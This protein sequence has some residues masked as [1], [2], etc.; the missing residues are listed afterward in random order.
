M[1]RKRTVAQTFRGLAR[2]LSR[3]TA[4]RAGN[5]IHSL[6]ALQQ[7]GSARRAT[8][9][10]IVALMAAASVWLAVRSPQGEIA[11]ALETFFLSMA[12]FT[13]IAWLSFDAVLAWRSV[14]FPWVCTSFAA[15]LVALLNIAEA[16]RRESFQTAKAELSRSF[17]ELIYATQSVITNDCHE[18]PTRAGMWQRAPEPYQGA[19]DRIQHFA[20]QMSH[21]YDE[22][23]RTSDFNSLKG[24]SRNLELV[25]GTPERGWAGLNNSAQR[26]SAAVKNYGP[27]LIDNS[28]SRSGRLEGMRRVILSADL[29]YWYFAMAFFVA[30]RLS[31]TTAEVFQARAAVRRTTS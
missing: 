19:C 23:A 6:P 12:G 11:I 26:V 30:L 1:A 18:L 5:A 27:A 9:T 16:T 31:K 28:Q 14:D 4:R 25:T 15:I 21:A 17:S 29:K 20:P 22:F 8:V 7:R 2:L 10:L 3:Y 24:W 13:L